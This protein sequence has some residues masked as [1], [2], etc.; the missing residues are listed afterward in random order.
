MQRCLRAVSPDLQ[1]VRRSAYFPHGL[2]DHQV[3]ERHAPLHNVVLLSYG[4]Y[5]R[6]ALIALFDRAAFSAQLPLR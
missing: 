1:R 2:A 5:D 3:R 4:V 6:Q